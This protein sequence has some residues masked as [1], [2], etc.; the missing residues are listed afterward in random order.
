[1]EGSAGIAGLIKA[2][3]AIQHK[4]IPP[5]MHFNQINP[6][7]KPFYNGLEV[8]TSLLPWPETG[9]KPR[10]AS[11]NSFGFGGTNA[12]AILE[13]YEPSEDT[14]SHPSPDHEVADTNI[15]RISAERKL[16]GPFVI[17][18]QS[19]ESLV[20][21]LK[22]LLDYLQA[23]TSVDLEALSHTLQSKRSVFRYRVAIAPVV[24]RED[25]IEKLEDQVNI[26]ST[27]ADGSLRSSPGSETGERVSILGIFTGQVS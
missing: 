15:R 20:N 4:A 14:S 18:A 1:L 8:P 17:S 10:R 19:R 5:N 26:I 2:S 27:S 16:T 9:G 23:N 22:Q 11:V 21:W 24:D 6:K 12:H 25:L 13:S 7:V 3:L